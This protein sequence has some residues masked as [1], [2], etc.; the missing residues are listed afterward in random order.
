M[1][2]KGATS[3]A[4]KLKNSNKNTA[5][6]LT[7][8]GRSCPCPPSPAATAPAV[9]T[10]PRSPADENGA[11][12]VTSLPAVLH[13]AVLPNVQFRHLS[14]A[15]RAGA[16]Q[17]CIRQHGEGGPGGGAYGEKRRGPQERRGPGEDWK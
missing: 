12:S 4:P 7:L 9:R 13:L 3:F 11:S 15:A 1:E 6:T 16:G 10:R 8:E 17:R 5:T 2:T 14:T